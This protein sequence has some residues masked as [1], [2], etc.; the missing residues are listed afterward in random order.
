MLGMREGTYRQAELVLSPS[1][2]QRSRCLF[3]NCV[4]VAPTMISRS[5][6]N[7]LICLIWSCLKNTTYFETNKGGNFL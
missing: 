6:R 7:V 1:P 5:E 4:S 2:S 3:I